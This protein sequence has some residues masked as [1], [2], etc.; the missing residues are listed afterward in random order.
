LLISKQHI[1][2]HETA[3]LQEFARAILSRQEFKDI[4]QTL[5][6][7]GLMLLGQQQGTK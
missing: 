1:K 2:T 3:Q 5:L 6:D 7:V 4:C